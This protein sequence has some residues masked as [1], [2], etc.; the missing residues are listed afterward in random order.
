MAVLQ[1]SWDWTRTKLWW[2]FLTFVKSSTK[3]RTIY[4]DR[5]LDTKDMEAKI[6]R[7]GAQGGQHRSHRPLSISS[8]SLNGELIHAQRETERGWEKRGEKN[9]KENHCWFTPAVKVP[10]S[11]WLVYFRHGPL[12]TD[13]MFTAPHTCTPRKKCSPARHACRRKLLIWHYFMF[14]TK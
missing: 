5:K 4:M 12:S 3:R 1:W 7:E 6:H 13:Y 10:S 8:V 2:D 9:T 14:T 11:L